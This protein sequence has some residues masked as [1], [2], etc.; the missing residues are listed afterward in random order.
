MSLRKA[1]IGLSALILLGA[2]GL[3]LAGATTSTTVA[4]WVGGQAAIVLVALVAERG[5]YRGSG[6]AQAGH[7]TITGERFQDP[8]TGRWTVVEYNPDSGERRYREE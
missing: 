5:R 2:V 3:A 8:T 4:L 1:L 7:W 6:D